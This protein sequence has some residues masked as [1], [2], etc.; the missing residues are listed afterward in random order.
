MV[1][2]KFVVVVSVL[3][4]V[5]VNLVLMKMPVVAGKITCGADP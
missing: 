5:K 3:C 1:I 2:F 4:I